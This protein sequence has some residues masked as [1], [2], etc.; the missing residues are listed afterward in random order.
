MVGDTRISAGGNIKMK[1]TWFDSV[2]SLMSLEVITTYCL[3]MIG[4][5]ILTIMKLIEVP[6]FLAFL[7]GFTGI[8]GTITTFYY[9]GKKR[10]EEN[11]VK[12]V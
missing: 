2:R 4:M 8:V 3:V 9:L 11:G 5:I 12:P 10:P 7:T 6:V 1:L